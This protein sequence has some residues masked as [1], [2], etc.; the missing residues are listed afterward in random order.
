MTNLLRP[1]SSLFVQLR[2]GPPPAEVYRR[3][4]G[5]AVE[6]ER[7]GFGSI[8]FATRHFGANHAALPAIFPF[9]GA[10][11]QQTSRIRL[12]TGVVALP[13]DNPVRLAEDAVVTDQLASGRLELGVGKGLGFGLSATSYSGFT[14][15]SRDRETL[16][17]ERL[18]ELHEILATGRVSEEVQLYPQP[19]SLRS[20]VWQST[21]N[22]GTALQVASAGDG[23]IPHGN[24]EASGACGLGELIQAYRESF[25]GAGTPRIG[26]TVSL[27]PADSRSDALALIETDMALSPE[28]Y[29]DHLGGSDVLPYLDKRGI[30]FGTSAALAGQLRETPSTAMAT[31]LLFHIPLAIEHPRYLE[32]L[33]RIATDI[34]PVVDPLLVR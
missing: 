10:V 29:V 32:C 1:A 30:E 31:E 9:L 23:L 16:Y 19:G 13:F 21:G 27:L 15:D 33:Q 5:V 2:S 26:S 7:L 28:Y 18:A 14:L 11:S 34:A 25:T 8:W 24:S 22:I 17:A 4:I 6:A 3:T 12:G 20:R